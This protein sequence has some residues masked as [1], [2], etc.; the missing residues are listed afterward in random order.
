MAGLWGE[1][2]YGEEEEEGAYREE[3]KGR[4]RGWGL[5]SR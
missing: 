4:G 1:E 3:R 2:E 5:E